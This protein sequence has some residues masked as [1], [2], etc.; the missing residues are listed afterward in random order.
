MHNLELYLD[1]NENFN[2]TLDRFA[3]INIENKHYYYDFLK[4]IQSDI[5]KTNTNETKLSLIYD[6]EKICL[7]K[8]ACYISDV[9]NIDF[10]CKS[11]ISGIN[12]QFTNFLTLTDQLEIRNNYEKCID[13]LI[14]RFRDY[15]DLNIDTNIEISPLSIAKACSPILLDD[16]INLV[17]RLIDYV[18]IVSKVMNN[19][20]IFINSLKLYLEPTELLIFHKY[21][22]DQE[23]YLILIE[24]ND[25]SEI[26]DNEQR[27]IID[28]QKCAIYQNFKYKM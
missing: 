18:D 9:V 5:D 16:K 17:D 1:L 11:I 28:K 21:C 7:D 15:S 12:K 24:S 13:E 19:K 14:R 23:I 10:N 4:S 2:L 27:M 22:R 20:V 6:G 26:L 25:S 3:T 8:I